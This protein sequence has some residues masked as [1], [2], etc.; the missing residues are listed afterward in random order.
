MSGNTEPNLRNP[1]EITIG[2]YADY[3]DTGF[4][5]FNDD[6]FIAPEDLT[7]NQLR[8]FLLA[9]GGAVYLGK[10]DRFRWISFVQKTDGVSE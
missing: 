3:F 4:W 7:I 10:D 2:E 5:S 6:S 8:C 1:L 9:S